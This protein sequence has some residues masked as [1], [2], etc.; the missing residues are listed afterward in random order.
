MGEVEKVL[1]KY[2]CGSKD[3]SK[4]NSKS[5]KSKSKSKFKSLEVEGSGSESRGESELDNKTKAAI[6]AF[7]SLKL[8]TY[9]LEAFLEGL[10]GTKQ[11]ENLKKKCETVKLPGVTAGPKQAATGSK[12]NKSSSTKSKSNSSNSVTESSGPNSSVIVNYTSQALSSLSLGSRE[13]AVK[14]LFPFSI[15]SATDLMTESNRLFQFLRVCDINVHKDSKFGAGLYIYASKL[16]HS[17]EANC[18]WTFDRSNPS[19]LDLVLTAIRP[20]EKH[21][22]LTFSYLG[23][24]LSM[25]SCRES[26]QAT[27]TPLGF[28]CE[29]DR[30]AG[31]VDFTRGRWC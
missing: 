4:S 6:M 13:K 7:N 23:E 31:E 10:Y 25:L 28:E 1:G 29:C 26:R 18:A 9:I 24:G 27:L 17:C 14:K 16:S 19:S 21:E 11:L 22:L 12:S 5:S 30:C 8:C 15:N 20:I 2:Y 3:S